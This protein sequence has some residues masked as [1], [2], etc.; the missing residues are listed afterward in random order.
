[1]EFHDAHVFPG[2]VTQVLTQFPSK[3]NNYG[4][5]LI[6]FRVERR[7]YPGKKVCDNGVSN[8]QPP[9]SDLLTTE[10]PLQ[11]VKDKDYYYNDVQSICKWHIK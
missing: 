3:A 7:K 10:L 5:F 2:F 4:T 9:E 1:M 8:S 11:V 6:S